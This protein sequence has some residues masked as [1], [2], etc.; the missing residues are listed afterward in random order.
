M[1]KIIER[2]K[3]MKTPKGHELR[4]Y[5]KDNEIALWYLFWDEYRGVDNHHHMGIA[6]ISYEDDK[7]VVGW[8][9]NTDQEPYRMQSFTN[10]NDLFNA[11]DEEIAKR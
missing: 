8:L 11:L 2:Y 3:D 9:R 1:K 5:E 10:I 4:V 6:K 7:Y